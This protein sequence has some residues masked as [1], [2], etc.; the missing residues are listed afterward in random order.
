MRL[1]YKL[2][3]SYLCRRDLSL[4][5]VAYMAGF[6]DQWVFFRSAQRTRWLF[7][8]APPVPVTTRSTR[9]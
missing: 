6:Q 4:A 5:A 3:E 7:H 1:A 8:D 2:A 9:G